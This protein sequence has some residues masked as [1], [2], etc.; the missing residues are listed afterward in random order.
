MIAMRAPDQ[1]ISLP[2]TIGPRVIGHTGNAARR[3]CPISF[4]RNGVESFYHG[5]ARLWNEPVLG[6]LRRPSGIQAKPGP[7]SSLHRAS[8]RPDG[9]CVRSPHVRGN[10]LLGRGLRGLGR[11]GTRLRGAVAEPAEVGCVAHVEVGRTQRHT[12]RK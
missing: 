4:L 3:S 6:W 10:A 1:S 9:Q 5:K 12:Y 7:L 2:A 8:A 11:G